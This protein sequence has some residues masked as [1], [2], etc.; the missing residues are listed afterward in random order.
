MI[1]QTLH[2][3]WWHAIESCAFV[4]MWD[5]FT[6]AWKTKDNFE[7]EMGYAERFGCLWNEFLW[8][9]DPNAPSAESPIYNAYTGWSW[10]CIKLSDSHHVIRI[11]N[12]LIWRNVALPSGVGSLWLFA[13]GKI[14]GKCGEDC[15]RP[16]VSPGPSRASEQTRHMRRVGSCH[17]IMFERIWHSCMF[18][19]LLYLYL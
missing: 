11:L 9:T 5:D 10:R 12:G 13:A 7:W 15:T 16:K 3:L 6:E 19:Q 17:C 1:G 14:S 4:P 2:S 8:E 18:Y